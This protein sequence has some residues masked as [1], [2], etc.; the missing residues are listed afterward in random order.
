MD[1][2]V[3]AQGR[4]D[5]AAA[6]PPT[7]GPG[8]TAVV[9]TTTRRAAARFRRASRARRRRRSD[10]T[11]VPRVRRSPWGATWS[12]ARPRSPPARPIVV[13]D[14]GREQPPDGPVPVGYGGVRGGPESPG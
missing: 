4:A 7:T 6:A 13:L 9:V 12:P 2:A 5:V 8:A 1:V 10:D 14:R 11:V 3:V